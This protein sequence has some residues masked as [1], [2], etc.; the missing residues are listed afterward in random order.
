MAGCVS[1][2][3]CFSPENSCRSE[4]S[5]AV[6]GSIAKSCSR[7]HGFA[8]EQGWSFPWQ[9]TIHR[10]VGL[11]GLGER[12]SA[13]GRGPSLSCALTVRSS[14]PL[15]LL[16]ELQREVVLLS[17][18]LPIGG[19]CGELQHFFRRCWFSPFS[20]IL[21]SGTGEPVLS[22]RVAGLSVILFFDIDLGRSRW[23]IPPP[24]GGDRKLR[25]RRLLDYWFSGS[26]LMW[27]AGRRGEGCYL[28][29]PFGELRQ[30]QEGHVIVWAD[31]DRVGRSRQLPQPWCIRRSMHRKH[32]SCWIYTFVNNDYTMQHWMW[33]H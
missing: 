21:R 32:A 18:P 22:Q 10:V 20:F 31:R 5:F 16:S 9:G 27:R 30:P 33:L 29:P 17:L 7:S 23:T 4:I 6:M 15:P 24:D 28:Q 19:S 3:R 13:W 14:L 8:W 12:W 25:R 1:Q 26:H 11:R 2:A